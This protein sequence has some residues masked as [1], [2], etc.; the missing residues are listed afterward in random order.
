MQ[1][2]R[3]GVAPYTKWAK[4]TGPLHIF[5]CN[6][7]MHVPNF[8]IFGTFKLHKT[9]NEKVLILSIYVN[10]CS[11]EGVTKLSTFYAL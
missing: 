7:G 4:K 6:K 5:P 9:T 3:C 2:A 1:A 8:I 11:P 10:T